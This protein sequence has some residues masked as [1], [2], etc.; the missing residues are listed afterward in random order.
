MSV[1]KRNSSWYITGKIKKCDGT[2]YSYTKKAKGA[3]T[4]KDA[5]MFEA[6]FLN[7]Y[8]EKNNYAYKITFKA[9]CDEFLDSNVDVKQ[10]TL[11]TKKDVLNKACSVFGDKYINTITKDYLQKYVRELEREYSEEY[12][13]K[14]YYAINSV[15][16]YA[17]QQD[18]LQVNQMAKV[19]KRV[20]K[21][22]VKKEMQFWEPDEFNVF[23]RYVDDSTYKTLFTFLYHM[24][25]RK[26][27]TLALKW[28]D[29]D[30]QSNTVS[31]Y[32]SITNKIDGKAWEITSPKTQNSIRNI[33]MPD[34]VKESL[35]AW[36]DEQRKVFGFSE[37][38][39]VFGFYRPLSST[40]IARRLKEAVDKANAD[41][42]NLSLIRIH[43]F[44]H[45]HASYLIN[46]KSDKF[47]DFDIANRLGDTVNTLHDT[48]AHWFST[49]DASIIEMMNDNTQTVKASTESVKMSSYD[50][51]IKLK[52]LLDMQIITQEEFNIKKKQ[53]LGI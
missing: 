17:V 49:A 2:Y 22:K 39:F 31:I 8:Q 20:N 14:I 50:D 21:D 46:N 45:S 10:V 33:S 12:V 41:G 25:T 43:D 29:I 38:C 32:K 11:R 15:F 6:Y 27:E 40:T 48:Y 4:K 16:K 44:R 26:G 35:M 37:D 7:Q 52:E 23:I 3:K 53:I 9:L 47:T 34:I 24:G 28:K 13:S 51:L 36:K 42:H 5:Q 18:Y 19:R 30:F 1:M